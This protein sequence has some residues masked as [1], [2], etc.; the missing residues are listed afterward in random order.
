MHLLQL[1][2]AFLRR[3]ARIA[4]S[5]RLSLLAGLAGPLFMVAIFYYAARLMDPTTTADLLARYGGDYFTY[6]LIGLAASTLLTTGLSTFGQSLR[7]AMTE[8]TLDGMLTTPTPPLALLVLPGLWSFLFETLRAALIVLL[9][10]HLFGADLSQANLPTAAL[11]TLLTLLTYTVFGLLSAAVILLIKRGDPITWALAQATA[12]LAGAW[13]PVTLLPDWLQAA[14][15]LL[16]MTYAFDALRLTL[17][18]GAGVEALTH[19][20]L[21]LAAFSAIGLGAAA[22]TCRHAIT[23][24]RRSGT[25]GVF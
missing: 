16:P 1:T 8:G 13:F 20:L 19:E 25:L 14:A 23:R 6:V 24:A 17:L 2:W 10:A 5:Y 9:G 12:L 15:R 21:I 11:V 4:A 7:T 18:Q 22:W 3:D